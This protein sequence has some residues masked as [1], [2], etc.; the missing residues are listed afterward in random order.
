MTSD[1]QVLGWYSEGDGAVIRDSDRIVAR[2]WGGNLM[3][4]D[5]GVP[6]AKDVPV[7]AS[8][9]WIDAEDDEPVSPR[10]PGVS[11]RTF[12]AGGRDAAE[13]GRRRAVEAGTEL[14]LRPSAASALSDIPSV[15]A[16]AKAWGG[17]DPT[18]V[19]I[20]P[21]GLFTPEMVRTAEDH[22]E[23]MA[24]EL[25]GLEPVWGVLVTDLR[26]GPGRWEAAPIGAGV[27]PVE[28]LAMVARV[29]VERG[30]AVVVLGEPAGQA[31]LLGL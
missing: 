12:M 19:L 4:P 29:A 14:I 26:E 21:A 7:I 24:E 28:S 5:A 3:P 22:L 20:D 18:R 1:A 31:A 25:I 6:A 10:D 30:R 8:P 23:R 2:W 16:A 9:G 13:A 11:F 27:L 15:R 17:D